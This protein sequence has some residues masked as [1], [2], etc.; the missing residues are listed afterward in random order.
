MTD[1]ANE[2]PHPP[3]TAEFGWV[4]Q[5]GATHVYPPADRMEVRKLAVSP[6]DNNVYVVGCTARRKALVVDASAKPSRVIPELDGF[7]VV[8]IAIT[9]SHP[10][11]LQHLDALRAELG[12]PPV[13][14]HAGVV[15]SVEAVADGATISVGD[16]DI[17][18]LHTPGHTPDS[19][20]LSARGFLF[21][22]DTL[23]PAGP[24]NTD[25]DAGRFRRV[26]ASVDRLMA[27]LPDETRI[28][29]GHGLDSTLGR[30]RPFVEVWR[31]RG[32]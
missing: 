4:E 10:D 12:N 3:A 21:S 15:P 32:W 14:G 5:D 11:H 1:R 19:I 27:E 7:D 25:G 9:H 31:A 24:G 13:Y 23:F 29:P 30:E 2:T 26:M 6:F 18:V 28:C 20:C 8:G 16:I 22:G 17:R